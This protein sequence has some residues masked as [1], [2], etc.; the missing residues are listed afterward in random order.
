MDREEREKEGLT[1]MSAASTVTGADTALPRL[2]RTDFLQLCRDDVGA[3]DIKMGKHRGM[4]WPERE[5]GY[6]FQ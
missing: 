6:R 3:E 1:V 5:G 2:D 4:R